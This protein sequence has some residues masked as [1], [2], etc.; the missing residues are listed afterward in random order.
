MC[1]LGEQTENRV[2]GPFDVGIM[3]TLDTEVNND[4]D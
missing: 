4:S 1:R 2:Q 3:T